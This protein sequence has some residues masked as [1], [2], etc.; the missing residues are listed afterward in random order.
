MKTL[1]F[2]GSGIEIYGTVLHYSWWHSQINSNTLTLHQ[3]SVNF[4]LFIDKDKNLETLKDAWLS[5]SVTDHK[6]MLGCNVACVPFKL[7]STAWAWNLI[8]SQDQTSPDVSFKHTTHTLAHIL[9]TV[10]PTGPQVEPSLVSRCS[11]NNHLSAASKDSYQSN[12]L[13]SCSSS[14]SS[15]GP[16]GLLFG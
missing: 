15:W 16:A 12:A 4:L 3:K 9:L 13:R 14:S 2:S 11:L 7:N 6:Q 5:E 1:H 8:S 10:H